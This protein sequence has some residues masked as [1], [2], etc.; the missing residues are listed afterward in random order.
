[1]ITI[2][3]LSDRIPV[4]IGP[5]EFSISPM[6]F[7]QKQEI[8]SL[9]KMSSGESKADEIGMAI[10]TIKY[11]VKDVKGIHTIDG[12]VY[13]VSLD[14]NGVLTDDC[15]SELMQLET[16]SLLIQVLASFLNGIKDPK[17]KGVEVVLPKPK[18]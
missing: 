13:Q 17:I 12:S 18:K 6:S 7:Q 10:K 3:K 16:N 2:Y 15:V 5:I 14:E 8:L 11:S 4:K 1:M 9:V